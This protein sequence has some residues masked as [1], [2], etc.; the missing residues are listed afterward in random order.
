MAARTPPTPTPPTAKLERVVVNIRLR[1]S[2]LAVVQL[3]K[4]LT[5]EPSVRD[6]FAQL[7]HKVFKPILPSQP[8][9]HTTHPATHAPNRTPA[10]M[11]APTKFHVHNHDR[12]YAFLR[13]WKSK[14]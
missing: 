11:H 3:R 8:R 9:T 6:K 10:E 1:P 4:L 5:R 2:L 14:F 12:R 13:Y 7:P